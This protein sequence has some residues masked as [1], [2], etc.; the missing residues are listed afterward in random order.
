MA[1]VAVGAALYYMWNAKEQIEI[2]MLKGQA[3]ENIFPLDVRGAAMANTNS[4]SMLEEA[5]L[6]ERIS[7]ELKT[8]LLAGHAE[9]IRT[10]TSHDAEG[11]VGP[12]RGTHLDLIR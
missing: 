5:G 12:I 3:E 2:P 7:P 8:L 9:L 6:N 10:I 1:V 4:E 11:S